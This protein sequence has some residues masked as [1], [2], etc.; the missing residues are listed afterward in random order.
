MERRKYFLL[1]QFEIVNKII[2]YFE[3]TRI[4]QILDFY[5]T[6]NGWLVKIHFVTKYKNK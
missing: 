5:F 3:L 1:R 2:K 4:F 6:A